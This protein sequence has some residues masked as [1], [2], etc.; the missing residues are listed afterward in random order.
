MKNLSY[1]RWL[2]ALLF[3]LELKFAWFLSRSSYETLKFSKRES[4]FHELGGSMHSVVVLI[5]IFETVYFTCS[6]IQSHLLFVLC[7]FFISHLNLYSD[8]DKRVGLLC[9]SPQEKA[10]LYLMWM[11]F[12]GLHVCIR[13]FGQ[14]SGGFKGSVWH[15]AVQQSSV[16]HLGGLSFKLRNIPDF[17]VPREL[18][19]DRPRY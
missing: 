10:V 5:C 7:D 3:S 13:R 17:V 18:E 4:H 9:V 19:T 12:L 2:T 14:L 6:S 16:I 11:M 1:S 8:D 15:S